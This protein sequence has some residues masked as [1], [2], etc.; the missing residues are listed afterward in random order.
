M[1]KVNA[2]YHAKQ[3]SSPR[4]SGGEPGKEKS[5]IHG[6]AYSKPEHRTSHVQR[7]QTPV[8]IKEAK[9]PE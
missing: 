8:E 5:E 4:A 7:A 3:N 9:I 6:Q 1:Q 2:I